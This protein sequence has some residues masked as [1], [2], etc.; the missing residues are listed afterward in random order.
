MVRSFQ[1]GIVIDNLPSYITQEMLFHE[2]KNQ[3]ID[4]ALTFKV[5][6]VNNQSKKNFFKTVDP[7]LAKKQSE[8]EQTF[9]KAFVGFSDLGAAIKARNQLTHTKVISKLSDVPSRVALII[10]KDKESAYS[11]SNFVL[12]NL[13]EN[14]NIREFDEKIQQYGSLVSTNIERGKGFVQFLDDKEAKEFQKACLNKQVQFDGKPVEVHILKKQEPKKTKTTLYF[15]EYPQTFPE[16][17]QEEA[18]KTIE[19]H[20]KEVLKEFQEEISSIVVSFSVDFKKPY[21][22]VNFKTEEATA[23]AEKVYKESEVKDKFNF[24]SLPNPNYKYNDNKHFVYIKPLKLDVTDKSLTEVLQKILGSDGVESVRVKRP[25]HPRYQD[26]QFAT[27]LTKEANKQDYIKEALNEKSP[28]F[29]KEFLALFTQDNKTKNTVCSCYPY[30]RHQAYLA[31]RQQKMFQ[32]NNYNQQFQQQQLMGRN[33]PQMM[34][35]MFPMQNQF[36]PQQFMMPPQPF[37]QPYFQNMQQGQQRRHFS[38]KPQYQNNQGHFQNRHQ[39]QGNQNLRQGPPQGRP[40]YQ[41]N[42]QQQQN[43]FQKH[44]QPQQKFQPGRGGHQQPQQQQ[45]PQQQQPVQPKKIL[46]PKKIDPVQQ[47]R[48]NLATF[49]K[50]E[51]RNQIQVLGQL[52]YPKVAELAKNKVLVNKIIQMLVDLETFEVEEVLELLEDRQS[53]VERVQE[54][55]ELLQQQQ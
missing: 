26:S 33:M 18:K 6:K 15:K 20:L 5:T 30:S 21:S 17:E 41:Q 10:S 45:K 36:M 27:I 25:T 13:P 2:F 51:K 43:Q 22:F 46:Q 35:G 39:S 8:D 49:K 28:H 7:K 16:S 53:L 31:R 37:Q 47:L 24:V 14:I 29:E 9:V 48:N 32:N 12:M 42:R 11:K 4:G 40:N 3:K 54:S 34:F 1:K 50:Q 23:K 52:I 38:Q 19:A 55:E 44:R